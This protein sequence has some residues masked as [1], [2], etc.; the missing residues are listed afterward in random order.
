MTFPE[1]AEDAYDVPTE[2]AEDV[3]DVPAEEPRGTPR[4][5]P[6]MT[7]PS[8]PTEDR[9]GPPRTRNHLTSNASDG[10]LGLLGNRP[11]S[12]VRRALAIPPR[13]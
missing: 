9:R 6:P 13:S 12:S 10:T 1:V 5:I 8:E 2:V 7:F 4:T 3:E 11:A